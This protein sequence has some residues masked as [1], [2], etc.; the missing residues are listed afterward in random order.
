MAH[1][2]DLLCAVVSGRGKNFLLCIINMLSNTVDCG[3]LSHPINGTVSLAN[4]VL[5][6]TATYTCEPGNSLVGNRTR[7]CQDD[8]LWTG[9]A[10]ICLSMCVAKFS[11]FSIRFFLFLFFS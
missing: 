11:P 7:V 1:G 3:D 2:L 8:G 10:P 4:T 5:N 9:S 6:S